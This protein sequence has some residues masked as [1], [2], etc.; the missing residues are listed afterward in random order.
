MVADTEDGYIYFLE[1]KGA[2]YPTVANIDL[3]GDFTAEGTDWCRIRIPE[4]WEIEA[5]TGVT[6]KLRSGGDSSTERTY[7]RGYKMIFHGIDVPGS[8][9]NLLDKF[10]Q[11]NVHT[12]TDPSTYTTYYIVIRRAVDDYQKFTDSGGTQ[13]DCAPFVV[14]PSWKTSW[15]ESQHNVGKVQITG[16]SVFA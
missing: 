15:N 12:T 3:A 16:W 5:F 6:V 4:R 14:S 8:H 7:R 10:F 11:S 2:W 1:N 9:G 13:R